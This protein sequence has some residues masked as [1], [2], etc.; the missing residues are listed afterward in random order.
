MNGSGTRAFVREMTV[1]DAVRGASPA[2]TPGRTFLDS[3]IVAIGV[4]DSTCVPFDDPFL[5]SSSD[6]R[7]KPALVL[8]ADGVVGQ[9][10]G[11]TPRQPAQAQGQRR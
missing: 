5:I 11:R 6:W 1:L 9:R 10:T 3:L 8:V 2:A 7:S 4:S